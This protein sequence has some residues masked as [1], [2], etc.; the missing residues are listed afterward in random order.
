[1]DAVPR[2]W[3][4]LVH[5]GRSLGSH[6]HE[7]GEHDVGEPH[8]V[9]ARHEGWRAVW[10]RD[11]LGSDRRVSNLH[12]GALQTSGN[13]SSV[14]GLEYVAVSGYLIRAGRNKYTKEGELRL[15]GV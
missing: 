13:P 12:K 3:L 8:D 6:Y 2:R 7:V 1:M 15:L 14:A 4:H 11:N 5:G 9:G 10:N